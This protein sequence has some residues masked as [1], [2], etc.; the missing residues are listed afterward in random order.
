MSRRARR[1]EPVPD[2]SPRH[3]A[4]MPSERVMP[5]VIDPVSGALVSP[6]VKRGA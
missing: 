6:F 2:L 5:W 1:T 3:L 4:P